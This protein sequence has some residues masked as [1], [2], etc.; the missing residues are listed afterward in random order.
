MR[1]TQIRDTFLD[2]FAARGHHR[3][4]AAP[5]VPDDPTL[6]LANAGMA[7]FKP[8]FLGESEPA[9]RRATT[10]QKC[11]RTVDVENVGRTARHATFFEMLGNFSF[12]DYFTAPRRSPTPGSC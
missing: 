9:V 12:G 4:P 2:F 7:Q 8:W 3:L 5:L 6:L 10:V 1:S 11:V